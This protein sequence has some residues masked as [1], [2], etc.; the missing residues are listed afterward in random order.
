M[1]QME[2]LDYFN[3]DD[4]LICV[5]YLFHIYGLV[6]ILNMGLTQGATIVTLPR[7]ERI[8]FEMYR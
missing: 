4:T 8:S 1:R 6:V 7:F 3:R 2:G 5:L